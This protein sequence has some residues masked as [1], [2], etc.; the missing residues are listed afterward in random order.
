MQAVHITAHDGPDAMR[1][2]ELPDP[3]PAAGQVVIEVHCAGVNF[4]DLL[5]T[6][7]LYQMSPPV[8]FA[9]G[10]EVAGR[11]TAVGKGVRDV[12]E[13]DRVMAV[14]GFGGFA[15]HVVVGPQRCV[16]VPDGIDLEVAGAFAFTYGTSYHA[17]VDRAHLRPGE[18]LLVLGAAG[19]VGLAAVEIG[20]R[21]GAEVIAAAS[22]ADKLAL[23]T[24][25]GARHQI[26]YAT[27]DLKL[28]AKVLSGGAVDVVYDPVGGDY[29][30][31]ALRTL[32]PGGRHLVIGFATGVI[33]RI[34][35]NLTL[36]KQ[37]S[38]VGVAWGSWALTHPAAHAEN[39]RVLLDMLQA[40]SL[41]PHISK[42]YSLEG[43]AAALRD[44]DARQVHG[45]VVILPKR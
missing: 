29:S 41:R 23:A 22:T 11:V 20:S 40:G 19:G 37:C 15:T 1:L 44:M 24:E 42:R 36:L 31:L 14:T 6:R 5:M 3:T 16:R 8:P 26:D 43:A 38:I 30:E 18:K 34:P 10:G 12:A 13:G 33:P 25:H 17:L 45:K 4:P 9:A 7:G 32:A 28:R 2:V 35:L 21:L 27:E 39:M